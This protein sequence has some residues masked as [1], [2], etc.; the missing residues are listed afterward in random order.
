MSAA[1]GL[2]QLRRVDH[3][4]AR[5]ARVAAAYTERLAFE[6]LTPIGPTA[7]VT[8]M[9]WFVY[10][11]R[12]DA[13]IDR[14]GIIRALAADGIPSRPYFPSIHLQPFYCERFGFEAGDFPVAEA[15]SR[16]TLALPFHPNLPVEQVDMVVDALRRAVED[17]QNRSRRIWSVGVPA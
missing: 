12:F 3:L 11:V 15:A 6:G 5:R 8:K 14:D 10:V 13:R 7:G 16:S 2:A 1:V 17:A 4:L 9:S